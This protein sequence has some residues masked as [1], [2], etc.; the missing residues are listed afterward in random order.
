LLLQVK[1]LSFICRIVK[2]IIIAKKDEE[3]HGRVR[4]STGVNRE[5]TWPTTSR[6]ET[7][8]GDKRDDDVGYSNPTPCV[9]RVGESKGFTEEETRPTVSGSHVGK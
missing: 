4:P 1:E 3:I 7:D 5:G 9:G 2:E 6:R 8:K